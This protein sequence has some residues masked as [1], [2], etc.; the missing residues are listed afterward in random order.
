MGAQRK[1]PSP[2]LGDQGKFLEEVKSKLTFKKWV[3]VQLVKGRSCI[4]QA[5]EIAHMMSPI[6]K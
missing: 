4:V 3:G 5:K 1:N 6:K 2:N